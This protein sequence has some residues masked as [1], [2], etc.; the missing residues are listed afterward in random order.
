MKTAR[1]IFS[2]VMAFTAKA[3]L[4]E[5]PESEAEKII[6]DI[7]TAIKEA[8][9]DQRHACAEAVLGCSRYTTGSIDVN[10]AHQAVMNAEVKK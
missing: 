4:I 6:A 3:I 9:R 8:M 2:A 10:E 1:D 7:D 5:V